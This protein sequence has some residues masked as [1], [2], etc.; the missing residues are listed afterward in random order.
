MYPI[1]FYAFQM[2]FLSLILVR[3]TYIYDVYINNIYISSI[4]FNH[5]II[6]HIFTPLSIL[7]YYALAV[8]YNLIMYC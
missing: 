6:V 4:F 5:L 3:E 7:G 2:V 8:S 1:G